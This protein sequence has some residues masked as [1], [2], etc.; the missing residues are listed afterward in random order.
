MFDTAR[1]ADELDQ[2][3]ARLRQLSAAAREL[4]LPSGPATPH[5][6]LWRSGTA[7][8]YRYPAP[9]GS[10]GPPLLVVYSLVNRPDILDFTPQRSVLASLRETGSSVYLLDWGRPASG[11]RHLALEDYIDGLLYD[12]VAHIRH[13]HGGAPVALLGVCQGGTLSL[14]YAALYPEHVRGLI[15]LVTPVDFHAGNASLYHLSKYVDFDRFVDA[16]GLV[17][18]NLLNVAYVGLKPFRIL[19]QR[20]VDMLDIA[21]DPTA[22]ADFM[23]MEQWMYDSPDQAGEAFRQFAKRFYQDNDLVHDRLSLAGRPVRLSRLSMPVLNIYAR[24]DHLVPQA[25]ALALGEHVPA[26]RYRS[27][28]FRG[29]HLAVF[30]TRRAHT[31]LYPAVGDWL[32]SLPAAS[33]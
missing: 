2:M 13:R 4:K 15:T 10:E 14:C 19:S 11:D 33:A 27:I 26:D 22:L 28:E 30:V 17:P 18:A 6:E 5:E 9:D 24:D 12:A 23:R 29:G 25:S 21:E 8:L 20:Y 31:Q 32:R 7:R 1:L 3:R 16:Y